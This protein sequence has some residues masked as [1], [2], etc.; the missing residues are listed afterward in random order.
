MVERV[1][2][3]LG[4]F[5][6]SVLDVAGIGGG[7][8]CDGP[9][10]VGDDLFE[11]A[12]RKRRA[13]VC[14]AFGIERLDLA[15]RENL[16]PIRPRRLLLHK[17]EIAKLRVQIEQKGNTLIPLGIY[18]SAGRVKIE[19][20]LATGRRKFDK[21]EAVAKADADKRIRYATARERKQR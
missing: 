7:C 2:E 9:T 15:G 16:D 10:A 4:D 3:A 5:P 11:L 12:N 20:A 21:R 1:G 8:V 6:V 17:R 18:F 19:L 13:D 14:G